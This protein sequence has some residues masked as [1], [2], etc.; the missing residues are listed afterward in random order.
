[1]YLAYDLMTELAAALLY[2]PVLATESTERLAALVDFTFNLEAVRLQ[3][4]TLRRRTNQ[5]DW[6]T[7]VQE[8]RRWV[9]GADKMLSCF[10]A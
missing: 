8:L 5:R 7:S 4:S 1:V 2:C 3:T 10:H 6:A 9:Y